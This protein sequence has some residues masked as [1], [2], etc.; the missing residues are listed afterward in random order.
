VTQNFE[1]S[2]LRW[3]KFLNKLHTTNRY[4]VIQTKLRLQFTI[5][6]NFRRTRPPTKK[7]GANE[8]SEASQIMKLPLK[9]SGEVKFV[10]VLTTQS[11]EMDDVYSFELKLSRHKSHEILT[12]Q[13][14]VPQQNME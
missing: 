3:L 12:H 4:L 7:K 5:T 8:N 10:S 11:N 13:F 14:T 6:F 2:F 1:I 9:N